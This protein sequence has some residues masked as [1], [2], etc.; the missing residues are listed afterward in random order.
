MKKNMNKKDRVFRLLLA[1]FFIW[2][3]VSGIVTYPE[4]ILVWLAAGI[5]AITALAG[6]CPMYSLFGINTRTGK[7]TV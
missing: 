3:N 7:R 6:S 1:V 5:M 4:C 2:L